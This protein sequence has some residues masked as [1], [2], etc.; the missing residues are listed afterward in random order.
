MVAIYLCFLFTKNGHAIL[1]E[2]VG[3]T[4]YGVGYVAAALKYRERLAV[5]AKENKLTESQAL[6]I[7]KSLE[8][9]LTIPTNE[10]DDYLKTHFADPRERKIF[11]TTITKLQV[12]DQSKVVQLFM[13]GENRAVA[14]DGHH[15]IRTMTQMANILKKSEVLWPGEVRSIL[16]AEGRVKKGEL[17]YSFHINKESIVERLPKKATASDVM[18][19]LLKRKTGLWE[20]P[21]DAK[22]AKKFYG[23]KSMN[24]TNKDLTYLANKLGIVDGPRG[25]MYT[26]ITELPDST[27]R[28][29][30]GN[31]FRSRGLKSK[32]ISYRAYIEFFL[33]DKVVEIINKDPKKYPT[34]NKVLNTSGM[35]VMEQVHLM[36]NALNELDDVFARYEA[37]ADKTKSL[38]LKGHGRVDDLLNKMKLQLCYKPGFQLFD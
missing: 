24:A 17:I 9:L 27:M 35:R 10:M 31:F 6:K 16:K 29:L 23:K 32:K 18:L 20:N 14:T 8:E 30:M 19:A 21:T 25:V 28:T 15:R 5:I 33:G 1:P 38:T 11:L 2:Q 3:S 13:I 34:L 4:Q 36:E 22:F 37:I 12:T 7:Q 26:P